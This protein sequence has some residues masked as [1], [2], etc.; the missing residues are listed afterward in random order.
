MKDCSGSNPVAWEY[1]RAVD[2]W[3]VVRSA[4]FSYLLTLIVVVRTL[5]AEVTEFH[6]HDSIEGELMVLNELG[7]R[8]S[9]ETSVQ[10]RVSLHAL[11]VRSEVN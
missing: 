7:T 9:A 4:C 5:T 10:H 8:T 1:C 11:Q 6:N 3:I 2:N